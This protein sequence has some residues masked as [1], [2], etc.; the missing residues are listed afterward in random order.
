MN[1]LSTD[2]NAFVA[3]IDANIVD[4]TYATQNLF[5]L[6]H[7]TVVRRN[8]A[9]AARAQVAGFSAAPPQA[10]AGSAP[11]ASG[12]ARGTRAASG[13]SGAPAQ[14]P[15]WDKEATTVAQSIY[16]Q[17]EAEEQAERDLVDQAFVADAALDAF[18]PAVE[19]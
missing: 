17:V 12:R 16:A 4:K 18:E 6:R 11:G 19:A 2:I 3:G 9:A 14:P 13:G 8:A 5:G 1:N 7:E 10:P 15:M